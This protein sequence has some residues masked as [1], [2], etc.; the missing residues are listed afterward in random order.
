MR[1]RDALAIGTSEGT[2]QCTYA[3]LYG[4]E[5]YSKKMGR[6]VHRHLFSLQRKID[7]FNYL[8]VATNWFDS[9]YSEGQM[10]D[11]SSDNTQTATNIEYDP[12]RGYQGSGYV[13]TGDGKEGIFRWGVSSNRFDEDKTDEMATGLIGFDL[14]IVKVT[15]YSEEKYVPAELLPDAR[16]YILKTMEAARVLDKRWEE[17]YKRILNYNGT[18]YVKPAAFNWQPVE[19]RNSANRSAMIE[20]ARKEMEQAKAVLIAAGASNI[21]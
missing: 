12:S 6:K 14:P 20:Q 13:Y 15:E 10:R 4:E 9:Q 21:L 18:V 16:L 3:I 19:V 17:M 5:E 8:P 2:I 11:L 7:G 1:Y